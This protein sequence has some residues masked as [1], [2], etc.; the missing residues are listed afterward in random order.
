MPRTLAVRAARAAAEKQGRDIRVLQVRDLIAITD[1]FVI[2]S[3][4]TDRQVKAIG[5]EIEAELQKTGAK[6][7]RREGERDLHWLLLDYADVIVHVFHQEDRA[8]YELERLWK[9]APDV[10]WEPAT[11]KVEATT[12][13]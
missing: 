11:A 8:Y 1:Y 6:P 5:D 4:A 3:G 2:V 13:R 10:R 9:D 7:I 12:A